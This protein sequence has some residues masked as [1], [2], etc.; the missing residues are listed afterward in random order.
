[1]EGVSRGA[2]WLRIGAGITLDGWN[3]GGFNDFFIFNRL[4]VLIVVYNFTELKSN[5]GMF[6]VS[7]AEM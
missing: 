2:V 6:V 7:G 1:M 3:R 4:S 5:T